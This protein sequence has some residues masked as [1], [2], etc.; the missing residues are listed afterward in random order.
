MQHI[1]GVVESLCAEVE[2]HQ[3]ARRCLG[4]HAHELDRALAGVEGAEV[5][6]DQRLES[7]QFGATHEC[8]LGVGAQFLV[9]RRAQRERMQVDQ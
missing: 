1:L 4:R 3:A 2:P 8:L 6:R 5:G 7:L 9:L